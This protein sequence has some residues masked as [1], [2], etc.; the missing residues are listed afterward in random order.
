MRANDL[1]RAARAAAVL[2]CVTISG[3]A[4]WGAASA[5][6]YFSIGMAYFDM[7]KFAEAEKWLNRAR[8]KDK[9]QTAS[10]YNLGRIAF[11]TKRYEE[12][13]KHFEAILKRDPENIMALKAAAYTR[14]KTGEITKA[15][16]HYRKL[17]ELVPESADDGYN[18]ALVLYAMEKYAE[19]ES[20]LNR[21]EFALLD[22]NDVLL[23]YAR[24]QKAQNKVEAIDNYAKWLSNNTDP[25]VRYE[26]AQLLEGQELY[27]RA[28]EECRAAM[29]ALAQNAVDPS[30]AELHF[31]IARLLLIADKGSE[32]GITELKGAVSDGFTGVEAMEKLLSDERISAANR[33][34]I[35][36]IISEVKLAAETARKEQQPPPSAD[37]AAE[38]EAA[39]LENQT[40]AAAPP[41]PE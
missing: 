14:I 34:S 35:K 20:V 19:A 11:E 17:L 21:H 30:K 5:E 26:Y 29:S 9:T 41:V 37:G 12:A 27:A 32:E 16:A 33:D 1:W 15:E 38:A 24:T 40:E 8:T 39:A 23:L 4:S 25:K 6:E 28:L 7:G 31:H 2:L 36:T 22:N 3:C 18:Y 10:E 13:A